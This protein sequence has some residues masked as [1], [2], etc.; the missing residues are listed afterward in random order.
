MVGGL[1]FAHVCV[2]QSSPTVRPHRTPQRH[3]DTSI[4]WI[5]YMLYATHGPQLGLEW[6][7]GALANLMGTAS[8]EL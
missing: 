2:A 8:G 4:A 7:H 1:A 6:T 3:A 5:T